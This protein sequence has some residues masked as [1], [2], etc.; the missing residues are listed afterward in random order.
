MATHVPL[1]AA[2][3]AMSRAHTPLP[4]TFSTSLACF[5][6][7]YKIVIDTENIYAMM[8]LI[9]SADNPCKTTNFHDKPDKTPRI[10]WANTNYVAYEYS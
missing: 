1:S 4:R 6:L 2:A 10:C 3:V 9:K 8:P 5:Y 7:L